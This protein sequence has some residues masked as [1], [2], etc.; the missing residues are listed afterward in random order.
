LVAVLDAVLDADL[1]EDL[2]AVFVA[3]F[4]AGEVDEVVFL[5]AVDLV[6]VLPKI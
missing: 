4:L 5:L 2:V 1:V 6:G 3:V